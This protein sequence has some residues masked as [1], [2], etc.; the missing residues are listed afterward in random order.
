MKVEERLAR[1]LE[2][3]EH[4]GVSI[5]VLGIFINI[6]FGFYL[7]SSWGFIIFAGL[8][9]FNLVFNGM[10]IDSNFTAKEKRNGIQKFLRCLA[11]FFASTFPLV[12]LC[13]FIYA[14]LSLWTIIVWF[15]LPLLLLLFLN[16]VSKGE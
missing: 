4:H 8:L 2:M 15:F 14:G 12:P 10:L 1:S 3:I 6:F 7:G 13:L 16:S 11:L 9:L 5:F